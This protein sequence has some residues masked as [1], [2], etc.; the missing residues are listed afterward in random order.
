MLLFSFFPNGAR[1]NLWRIFAYTI[2]QWVHIRAFWI[3]CTQHKNLNLAFS[4]PG[5]LNI[6]TIRTPAFLITWSL[7]YFIIACNYFRK[8]YFQCFPQFFPGVLG[9]KQLIWQAAACKISAAFWDWILS[10]TVSS[11][12]KKQKTKKGRQL[13]FPCISPLYVII[14]IYILVLVFLN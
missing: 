14:L 8:L 9:M 7:S 3:L 1:H 10:F 5:H 6:S 12:L 13:F 11:F 4:I 2:I